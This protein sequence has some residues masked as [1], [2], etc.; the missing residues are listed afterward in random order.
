[1]C[2]RNVSTDATDS[3]Q[4]GR[5]QRA[6][7]GLGLG[8]VFALGC[9]G[10]DPSLEDYFPDTP[11]PTG[12]A[13]S[14]W[15]GQVTAESSGELIPGP[16]ASG[17]IGDYFMR[18]ARGRFVIQAPTRVIGVVPQGG[19]LVDAVPLDD[20]GN[21][22]AVDHFGELG[23]VYLVGRTCRHDTIEVLQD[24]S[25]GGAAVMRAIGMTE[26]NDFINLRGIG[27]LSVPLEIDPDI[28]DGVE[29]AT[30]Y[31]LRPDS[32]SLEVYWSLFNPGDNKVVGPVGTLND[33][34]GEV[35]SFGRT[36]GFERLGLDSLISSTDPAPTE[37][38]VYQGP[39]VAYGLLPRHDDAAK[40][41][42][43][44]QI[45]G[46]SIIL[47]GAEK[48]L[49][50][51]NEDF[52]DLEM[53]PN[54]GATYR[55]DISVGLDAGDVE[56]VYWGDDALAEVSGSVTWATASSGAAGAR[57][58]VYLDA[59]GNGQLGAEDPVI[60][61]FDAG[62]DGS[63]SGAL[64]PG[65]YLVNAEVQDRARSSAQVINVEA[66]GLSGLSLT[67][68]DAVAFD[69]EV[70]DLDTGNNMPAKLSIIGRHPVDPDARLFDRFDRT[71]GIVTQ[72]FAARG[73]TSAGSDPDEPFYLA[74]GT[75][76]IVA[77]RGTEWSV[78][79]QLVTVTAGMPSP[80]LSFGMRRV[81]DTTGYVS[82]EYHVHQVGSPDSPILLPAR[83]RS[84]LADGVEVFATTDHDYVTD[85]QPVIESLE[86]GDLVRAIPGLE[87]TPF[88]YGHFNAWPI[89]I[90]DT[91]PNR[92]AV[93]WAR[94]MEGF[95]M[96]PDEIFGA[97]RDRGAELVQVNH[98]RSA[99]SLVDFMQFFD[100]AGL[101]FDFDTRVVDSD[102]LK[103]PVPNDWM[104][105]PEASLWSD[106][107]NALEVWNGFATSDSNDDGVREIESLDIVMRDWFNFL[108]MGMRITPVGSSDTHSTIK[109]PMG[110]PRTFV[111]VADDSR[112]SLSSGNVVD[113][114]LD[115]LTGRTP[116]DLVITNGPFISVEASG[117][118]GSPI[119]SVVDA[120]AGS[121]TFDIV[122]TSPSWAEINTIEVFANET[123]DVGGDASDPALQPRFCFTTRQN[124]LEND[125]CALADGG[126]RPLT[127]A[128]EAMGDGITRYRGTA[129]I[130]LTPSDIQNRAGAT[131]QDAWFVVRVYGQRSIFP[132]LLNGVVSDTTIDT[133]VSGDAGERN[134]I[135]DGAGVPA[136]AF[137][138]PIYVDFDGGGY[139]AVFAP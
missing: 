41:N 29:C 15:A 19:N 91:T 77:S 97:M 53:Q 56:R 103:Q 94:G 128:T 125:T 63:F 37:Y 106:A 5:M 33:T 20:Q 64:V 115:S 32:T 135:L 126:A 61:Y 26:A 112:A 13:Q 90:D 24:G 136:A 83:V 84:A 79:E 14:V 80:T 47:F 123:V 31:V 65:N 39:K 8:L 86:V 4:N 66:A 57:V 55:M 70:T 18:N 105:L 116:V 114:I 25:G 42:S 11:Q 35:G 89:Q 49:D 137:T 44:F 34:G 40:T 50:I 30:T 134:A 71:S 22:A 6:V 2:D 10:S 27:L 92:G 102:L 99:Q 93:D 60:T 127:M 124:L 76:R 113:M 132:L 95:A 138:A 117:F 78:H 109:D 104:R 1:M 107:F 121:V 101:S 67:V 120:T 122:V 96:I 139:T 17:M 43:T 82:S 75:Y 28:D 7:L 52:W 73:T 108:S 51:L 129:S 3:S 111:R 68:P 131:G 38:V 88:T 23:L 9:G 12:E 118:T 81:I 110:M 74:P 58:G 62:D 36:R 87:V 46:V 130:T 16:A 72:I 69:F 45:T 54:K 48:L 21:D 59:D 133:L 85:L 98:P 100:R 119:G